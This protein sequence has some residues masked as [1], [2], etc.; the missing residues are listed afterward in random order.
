M[1][2]EPGVLSRIAF[3]LVDDIIFCFLHMVLHS[4]L[5]WMST[6]QHPNTHFLIRFSSD[7]FVLSIAKRGSATWMGR[8]AA[9]SDG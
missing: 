2:L 6:I 3:G 5:P 7:R 9:S 8:C 1:G 4:I